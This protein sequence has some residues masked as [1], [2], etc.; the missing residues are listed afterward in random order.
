MPMRQVG[1]R[2][3]L[4][5]IYNSKPAD[6]HLSNVVLIALWHH[7]S[8]FRKVGEAFNGCDN[9][10]DREVGVARRVFCDVCANRFD[11]PQGLGGPDDAGHRPRRRLASSWG[12]P[13]PASSS[14]R[15]ASILARNT[16]RSIA[17]STVAS[18]G[19]SR[20]ASIIPSRVS[21][22]DMIGFYAMSPTLAARHGLSPIECAQI[23]ATN[24][25][26]VTNSACPLEGWDIAHRCHSHLNATSGSTRAARRA[27]RNAATSEVA[28]SISTAPTITNGSNASTE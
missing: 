12:M 11:V 8:R 24:F 19:I 10:T 20:R 23:L 21:C 18:G 4:R 22:S 2:R 16:R 9:P 25:S 6:D 17:S 7:P 28:M 3:H 1:W 14:L 27:G 13:L 5:R 15:P 26:K